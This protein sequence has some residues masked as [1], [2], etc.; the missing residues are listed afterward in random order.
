MPNV[1]QFLIEGFKS[2]RA[3]AADA[4]ISQRIPLPEVVEVLQALTRGVNAQTLQLGKQPMVFYAGALVFDYSEGRTPYREAAVTALCDWRPTAAIWSNMFTFHMRAPAAE[5]DAWKPVIDIIRQSLKINPQWLAAYVKAAGE[6]GQ[7]AVEVFRYLAR[8]DQEIF[9]RRSKTR[10][11]IAHENYLLLTGQEDYVNPFT[12]EVE[13]D[14]SD[15][16]YRWTNYNGDRLY[17]NRYG[18][19]PNRDSD[20]NKTEWKITPVKPR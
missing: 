11:E 3:Q 18:F 19:D 17:T 4:R 12:R 13:R 7:T 1:E 16:P 5:A 20:L 14:S 10:S 9:E 6:R 15:Y 2:A 8:I